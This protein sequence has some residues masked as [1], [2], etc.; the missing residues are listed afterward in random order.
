LWIAPGNLARVEIYN[1]LL[2]RAG[3]GIMPVHL[4]APTAEDGSEATALQGI[5]DFDHPVFR[6][7][8]GRPDPVPQ[9]TVGRYFPADQRTREGRVL[10]QYASG[11]PFLVASTVGR[12]RVL[13]MTTPLDADWG[14]LPLSNFYLPF[15][16]SAARFLAG[17]LMGERNLTPGKPIVARFAGGADVKK[18]VVHLPPDQRDWKSV[19]VMRGEVRYANT[20]QP[21]VYL[22]VPN[23]EWAKRV[24][25]VVQTPRVESDLTP[26]SSKQWAD[27]SGALGFE[28]I[29]PSRES[30]TA[31]VTAA[32]GGKELWLSLVG[33]VI[34]LSIVEMAVVRRWSEG[35]V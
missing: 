9:V 6:F 24:H 12:G 25:F 22:V 15:A 14:T 23:G 26:L 30:I 31:S 17:G 13:V 4:S 2:H 35:G 32:R 21:G 3:S 33:V 11:K 29:E 27:L 18:A 7:L 5:S 1:S 34:I 28:R 16:Q 8:K 19:P 10:A 20:Q